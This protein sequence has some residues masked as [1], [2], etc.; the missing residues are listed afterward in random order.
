LIPEAIF[1]QRTLAKKAR[2][3]RHLDEVITDWSEF[4]IDLQEEE[5]GN[6]EIGEEEEGSSL[7]PSAGEIDER[8]RC[9]T[10]KLAGMIWGKLFASWS[11]RRQLHLE[12]THNI[13]VVSLLKKGN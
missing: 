13:V 12:Q 7:N 1:E 9:Q 6:K 5:E 11:S 3:W 4:N 10:L 8:W 2:S